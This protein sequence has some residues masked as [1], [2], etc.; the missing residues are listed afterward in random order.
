MKRLLL[1]LI[2]TLGITA[3]SSEES[4]PATESTDVKFYN[5]TGEDLN[6]L[7]IGKTSIGSLKNGSS[8][9]FLDVKQFQSEGDQPYGEISGISNST[10]LTATPFYRLPWEWCGTG[11]SADYKDPTIFDIIKATN[12]DG[13]TSLFLISHY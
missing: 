13:S 6:S 2:L 3:C 7:V 4:A 10:Q 8:T 1:L 5:K 12:K 9:E 11:R